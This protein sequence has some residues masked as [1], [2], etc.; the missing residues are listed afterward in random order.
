ME[1]QA[2]VLAAGRVCVATVCGSRGLVAEYVSSFICLASKA[3]RPPWS[4]GAG[5]GASVCA[6]YGHESDR[7]V[8][9]VTLVS[10]I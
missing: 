7:T 6:P 10:K 5:A 1:G 2:S 3:C 4:G 9:L 8:I